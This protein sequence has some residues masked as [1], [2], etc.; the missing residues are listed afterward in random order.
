M[1]TTEDKV[2]PWMGENGR[3]RGLKT[4][5]QCV[6]AGGGALESEKKRRGQSGEAGDQDHAEGASNGS[7]RSRMGSWSGRAL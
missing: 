3:V 4:A 7:S 6:I 1:E 2:R 5:M